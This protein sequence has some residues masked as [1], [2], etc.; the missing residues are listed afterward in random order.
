[1]LD[2]ILSCSIEITLSRDENVIFVNI[3]ISSKVNLSKATILCSNYLPPL[4]K[5][6]P[7]NFCRVLYAYVETDFDQTD[8]FFYAQPFL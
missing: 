5:E 7:S 3:N 6:G 8:M 4:V 2:V 1:M